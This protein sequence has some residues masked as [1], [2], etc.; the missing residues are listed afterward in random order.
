[1]LCVFAQLKKIVYKMHMKNNIMIYL[2]TVEIVH[3]LKQKQLI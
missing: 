3:S 1:M 2:V